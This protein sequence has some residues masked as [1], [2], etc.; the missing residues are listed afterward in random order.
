MSPCACVAMD[1]GTLR[2]K[3]AVARTG[4]V[5]LVS[6]VITAA[7]SRPDFVRGVL[8]DARTKL[9]GR[10]DRVCFAVPDPWLDAD[11]AGGHAFE[12]FRHVVE[13]EMGLR[14]VSWIGQAAAVT[15]ATISQW[16]DAG[17]GDYLICD[18]GGS[19][20]RTAICEVDSKE[21]RVVTARDAVG[22]GGQEFSAKALGAAAAEDDPGLGD[23]LP[24]IRQQA[25]LKLVLDRAVVDPG[26]LDTLACT[27]AGANGSYGL[28]GGQ[29]IESFAP[30]AERL[31]PGISAVLGGKRPAVAVLT[32]GL[33]WFPLAARVVVEAA[34]VSPRV[35]DPDAAAAG[36]LSIARGVMRL[37]PADLPP[38]RLPVHQVRHGMLEEDRLDLP[39]TR[40]FAS[41]G[42]EPVV[43]DNREVPLEISGRPR[44]IRLPGLASGS[45]LIGVRPG[46]A[47][48]GLLVLRGASTESGNAVH[49]SPLDLE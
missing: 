48:Q 26:F 17:S 12:E 16:P 31:Q 28:T 5:P 35:V 30:T 14:E 39:W 1:I 18:I 3:I 41:L 34:G 33:G 36:A 23:W 20:V 47:G 45:Y 6:S 25:R 11:V 27:L 2:T 43:F 19:G 37:A 22:G 46:S 10:L 40:S 15:A 38:V 9:G 32:G 7:G 29:L 4:G 8:A 49:I 24:A 42:D 13:D 44:T 21:I